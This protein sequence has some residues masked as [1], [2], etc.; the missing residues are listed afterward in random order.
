M[1]IEEIKNGNMNEVYLLTTDED[2][3]IV[4]TSNFDNSF[5]CKVLKILEEYNFNCP[6]VITNFKLGNKNIMLYKYLEGNNPE[7]Y[8]DLFFKKMAKLLNELHEVD[9]KNLY[10]AG[11]TN[12]ENLE[13]LSKY[14][15]GA[16]ESKYL[17]ADKDFITE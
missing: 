3:Y 5:E 16:I 12:E 11:L 9:Y 4:R 17:K 2:K 10:K 7:V 13:K 6:K 14:Y 8:N 15:T 1:K